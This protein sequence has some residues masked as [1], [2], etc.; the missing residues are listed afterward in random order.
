MKIS[1]SAREN[2]CS[3]CKISVY[4]NVN[5]PFLEAPCRP[6]K[7]A[8]VCRAF[9]LETATCKTKIIPRFKSWTSAIEKR[10]AA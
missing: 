6:D 1:Q 5:I 4:V 10:E 2:F 8:L 7:A 3:H 9:T